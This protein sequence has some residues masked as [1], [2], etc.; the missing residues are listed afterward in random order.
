MRTP[1]INI[2]LPG[3]NYVGR[4]THFVTFC[5]Q[6]RRRPFLQTEYAREF[7]SNFR[8]FAQQT[9]FAVHAY[10]VMPDHLHAL[11]E[12]ISDVSD[13]LSFVKI[14]KQVTA[15]RY[16]AR[17]GQRLWQRAYYDHILRPSD[18]LDGVAWYIWLN[19]VRAGLCADYKDYPLSG[20]FT[21]VWTEWPVAEVPWLPA[22]KKAI[23]GRRIEGQGK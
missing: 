8:E 16:K 14:F 22:W 21:G 9:G 2:R 18:S 23:G 10:C 19:P 13:L 4:C 20:S 6:D 15:F 11:V 12:G 17:T 5:C 1:R 7:I 3:L